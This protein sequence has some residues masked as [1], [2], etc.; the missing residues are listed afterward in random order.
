M[1]G[2]SY[3]EI[4][5]CYSNS[6]RSRKIKQWIEQEKEKES[7]LCTAWMLCIK[8]YLTGNTTLQEFQ[9][10]SAEIRKLSR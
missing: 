3:L 10:T 4:I 8:D 2:I 7:L 9:E 6:E 1:E 5:H